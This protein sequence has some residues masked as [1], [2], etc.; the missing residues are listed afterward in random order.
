ML[1]FLE[2]IGDG[3][4]H[5]VTDVTKDLSNRFK[6]NDE[7]RQRMLPS[8]RQTVIYNRTGWAPNFVKRFGELETVATNSN[9]IED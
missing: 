9:I 1:P 4:E 7:K 6:L 8:G 3:K 2:S 5:L